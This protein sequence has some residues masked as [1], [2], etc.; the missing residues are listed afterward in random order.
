LQKCPFLIH[1]FFKPSEH[2]NRM[3]PFTAQNCTVI[4]DHF[5]L[6]T[7]AAT[8]FYIA[9]PLPYDKLTFFTFEYKLFSTLTRLIYILFPHVNLQA[10]LCILIRPPFSITFASFNRW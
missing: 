9:L 1:D 2:F 4:N 10:S 8:S 5:T 6:S 7:W 3:L